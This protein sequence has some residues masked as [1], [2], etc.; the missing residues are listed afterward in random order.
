MADTGG[1]AFV[2]LDLEHALGQIGD[3]GALR[4]MLEMLQDSLSRDVPQIA[5]LLGQGDAPGANRL[6][7]ALKGF[8][9]IFCVDALCEH[10]VSVERL[11]KTAPAPE[12]AQAYASLA[13]ELRQ[14]QSEISAHMA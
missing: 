14:L 4:E 3:E 13:P 1:A 5:E 2:Y 8:I 7:H 11:S 9:P 10:V 6:L 12:I